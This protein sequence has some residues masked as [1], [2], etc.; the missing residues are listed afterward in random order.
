MKLFFLRKKNKWTSRRMAI[1]ALIVLIIFLWAGSY[2]YHKQIAS[3]PLDD[4]IGPADTAI[5]NHGASELADKQEREFNA[6][7]EDLDSPEKV[8]AYIGDN[9]TITTNSGQTA[10]APKEL[11]IKN[12]GGPQ[13][14]AVFTA[15]LLDWNGYEAGVL[16]YAWLENG[17]KK[18]Y[19]VAVFR[20]GDTPKYLIATPNKIDLIAHGWSFKDLIQKEEARTGF[21]IE[22]YAFFEPGQINLITND[23]AKN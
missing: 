15:F 21:K 23:W 11:F 1:L 16:E 7:K 3:A 10:L 14:I 8:A 22:E 9:F 2:F 13:D 19:A 20:D 12:S 6:L 5:L 17:Q 18:Y 4:E